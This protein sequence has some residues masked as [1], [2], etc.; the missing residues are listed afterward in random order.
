MLTP[1]LTDCSFVHMAQGFL[2][3]RGLFLTI[4]L[5]PVGIGGGKGKIKLIKKSVKGKVILVVNSPSGQYCMWSPSSGSLWNWPRRKVVQTSTDNRTLADL[6]AGVS[7]S[8]SW[9]KTFFLELCSR[10]WFWCVS[11]S[12]WVPRSLALLCALGA[13]AARDVG[14]GGC[15]SA[16]FGVAL[17]LV[18][19]AGLTMGET[20]APL[21][22]TWRRRLCLRE[23]KVWNA[24]VLI[25]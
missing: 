24:A 23:V 4:F 13:G 21:S 16:I 5:S 20:G 6:I 22:G 25:W 12:P 3:R 18:R 19:L 15:S 9:W 14:A 1:Y 2:E 17:F 10:M 11:D 8:L 7:F